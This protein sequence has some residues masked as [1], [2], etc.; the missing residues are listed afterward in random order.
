MSSF[1]KIRR[2][3]KQDI[4]QAIFYLTDF[5][6]NKKADVREKTL[7]IV[8]S[9][10][11]GD[12]ILFRNFLPYIRQS[13]K[14]KDYKI[15]LIGNAAWKSIAEALD[16][17]Y[18][19]EMIWVSFDRLYKNLGYRSRIIKDILSKGYETLFYPVYSGDAYAEQF[20]IKKIVAKDKVKI[21]SAESDRKK[22]TQE[23]FNVVIESKHADVFE[24]YRYKE[25]VETFFEISIP[26]FE[27]RSLTPEST[28]LAPLPEQPY[29]V[30]FPSSSAYLKRWHTSNFAKVADYLIKQY[31][32]RIV[33]T[34]SKKDR[35]YAKA[36]LSATKDEYRQ[37]I[38]DLTG[39]T[40]LLDLAHVIGHGELLVTND[41]VSIHMAAA[42][43]VKALCVFMGENYGRFAP[44]PKEVYAK[45]KFL[46]PPDVERLVSAQKT[47]PVFLSLDYDPDINA[48]SVERVIALIE[49]MM[50]TKV[51]I[52]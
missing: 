9:D 51:A 18:Y 6:M 32:Y 10:L 48:I 11:I 26:A 13:E 24:I 49:E 3:I 44:Y 33:L 25:L 16:S 47:S 1:K 39:K 31:D 17:A 2:K 30:F 52:V 35:K 28:Q 45:G 29:V 27:W 46:C 41:S 4:R 8:K 38:I 37:H 15:T 34:G 40:S 20:F 36:I 23:V 14:Y 42:L 43:N 21:L 50:K 5:R 22:E 12:Y 7:V 19:D